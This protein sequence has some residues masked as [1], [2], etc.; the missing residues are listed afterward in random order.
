MDLRFFHFHFQTL[1]E[2]KHLPPDPLHVNV[3]G[4]PKN[5]F[6][7]MEKVFS[8]EKVTDFY[9]RNN[10][11]SSGDAAGGKFDGRQNS[12]AHDQFHQV[13]ETDVY[14]QNNKGEVHGTR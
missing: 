6:D 1:R 7:L 2:G 4:P 5:L 13:S 14:L 10:E 9:R 12:S 11:K 3:L 8:K